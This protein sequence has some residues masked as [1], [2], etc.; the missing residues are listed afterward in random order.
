MKNVNFVGGFRKNFRKAQNFFIPP[1][2]FREE[3]RDFLRL[4]NLMPTA[5]IKQ[6]GYFFMFSTVV[7]RP[8]T[9]IAITVLLEHFVMGRLLLHTR[10]Q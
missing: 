1:S 7:L 9:D 6:E 5:R 8:H 10:K 2:R 4:C 3:A